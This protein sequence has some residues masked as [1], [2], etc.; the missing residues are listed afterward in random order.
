MELVELGRTGVM[1]P[2][3][4]LGTWK[5]G[6]GPEP[7]RRGIQL[8]AFLIDTAEMY[9][10]EDAVGHAV[11]P[12]REQ[13]FIATKVLGSHLRRSQVLRA[14]EGSLRQLGVD[15]IDLYQIHWPDP[16]VPIKETMG[17][18]EELVDRKLVRYIGVSNF[19]ISEM[20][21]AQA[22][23]RHS[24]IVSNQV[25]YNLRWREIEHDLLPYCQQHGVT[26]LAYTPL[27][28]GELAGTGQR[29][30]RRPGQGGPKD[31]AL[32]VLAQVAA[33]TGKTQAQVTL[34]WCTAH[35]R[36]I[37]IPKSDSVARTEENCGASGWRLT[38]SQMQRLNEAFAAPA[39][40]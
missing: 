19:S 36:V 5:Y 16:N 27:N 23:L 32:A 26:V 1:L 9:R 37:A 34:N 38:A 17:A 13:V 8:G 29:G 28:D 40:P 39:A 3:I 10:T 18:L 25:L 20:Q 15:V 14:A 2:E 30:R 33:E 11:R 4:G 35:P 7:L 22:A 24:P 6:G 21:A 31:P 12:I